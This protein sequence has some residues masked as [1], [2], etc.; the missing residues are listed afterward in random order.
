[1]TDSLERE[2]YKLDFDVPDGL[3]DRAVA[4]AT[5]A[6]DRT[7]A[8]AQQIRI[9]RRVILVRGAALVVAILFVNLLGAYF[10]PRYGQALADAPFVGGVAAP[11][12]R[13]SGLDASE[14]T[15]LNVSA[16]SAG[17]TIKL[18]GGYADTERT[19]LLMEFDGKPHQVP[20][21]S[22]HDP[23]CFAEGTLTDQFALQYQRVNSFDN[24][25][26]TF[27]PVRGPASRVGARL[28][29]HITTLHTNGPE[30]VSGDWW[31]TV[32]LFQQAGKVLATPGPVTVNGITYTIKSV[33]L[34]GT[35]V[36]IQFYL[37]GPRIEEYRK[38]AYETKTPDSAGPDG[39]YQRYVYATLVDAQGN[40]AAFRESGMT[41]P[42][43]G[44]A[45]GGMTMVVPAPGQ[46][47]LT[48][49]NAPGGPSFQIDIP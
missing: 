16:T 38:L 45:S 4:G 27:E 2:L 13:Y 18:V 49:G 43:Q 25:T 31:L 19:V 41:M 21:K 40:K 14:I 34:S 1:M 3:V 32:T 35:Q 23:C 36:N 15:K 10:A 6:P 5:R 42:K 11:V 8:P 20:S 26:A 29:L 39:F 44:P 28:T 37:S 48:F 12:L 33:R 9:A 24:Q 47:T 30:T 7:H 22:N 46:Y 17:H